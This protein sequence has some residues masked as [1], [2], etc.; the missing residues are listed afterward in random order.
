M[1]VAFLPT[2]RTEWHGLP[3]AFERLFPGHTF[4]VIPSEVE[5]TSHGERYPLDGITSSRLDAKH[6]AIPPETA[7]LLVERASTTLMDRDPPDLLVIL[8]DLELENRDQPDR[9]VRVF[10]AAV[11]RHV[12]DADARKQR[13]RPRLAERASFHLVAPMIEAWFFGDPNAL[14]NAGVVEKPILNPDCSVEQFTTT[15]IGYLAATESDCPGWQ[16]KSQKSRRPKWFGVARMFHP[17]GYLQW[18]TQD[19]ADR[20]CTR[21]RET[22]HGAAALRAIDWDAL[23]G[24][25]RMNFLNALCEDIAYKL[26][27]PYQPPGD[28]VPVATSLARRPANNLL[29][30]L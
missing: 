17:K 13:A 5:V 10:R 18:L 15:D 6:E 7:I 30:N 16:R 19:S 14:A 21:Y 12:T 25:A 2:G 23:R 1:R 26:D 29:R 20:N 22:E 24:Q 4:E 9:V 8:D 11:E 3:G 27:A 28:V